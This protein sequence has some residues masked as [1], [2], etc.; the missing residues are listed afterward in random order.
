MRIVKGMKSIKGI[1]DMRTYGWNDEKRIF[2]HD[3]NEL[4]TNYMS[5]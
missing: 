2:S 4:C 5:F 3:L 1:A